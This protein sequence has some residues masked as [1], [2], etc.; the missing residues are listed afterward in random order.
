MYGETMW[1]PKCGS[2]YRPGFT[3]CADWRVPLVDQPYTPGGDR[4]PEGDRTPCPNRR[5]VELT[6]VPALEANLVVNRLR[7]EGAGTAN[8]GAEPIYRSLTFTEGVPI[9]IAEDELA[10][11]TEILAA[12]DDEP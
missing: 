8:L 1:C 5:F 10:L 4:T 2:E 11:A 7:A 3:A 6:R 12:L 9:L